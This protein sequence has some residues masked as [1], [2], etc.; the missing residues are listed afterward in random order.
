M[1][2]IRTTNPVLGFW[3]PVV[4]KPAIF[5]GQTYETMTLRAALADRTPYRKFLIIVGLSLIGSVLFSVI[6]GALSELI[7]GVGLADVQKSVPGANSDPG[8]CNAM[9][10]I[11]G[12]SLLGTFFVPALV[13]AWLFSD[14]SI[15]F[16]GA[17]RKPGIRELLI[18]LVL[19]LCAVP[20]I[21]WMMALNQGISLPAS[22]RA[23]EDWMHSMEETASRLTEM[24]VSGTSVIAQSVGDRGSSRDSGRIPF[25]WCPAATVHVARRK[26]TCRYLAH[27]LFV[28]RVAH[29]ISR[30]SSAVHAG[31]LVGIFICLVGFDLASG[32]RT[33]LQQCHSCI[34]DLCLRCR[35]N[36]REPGSVYSLR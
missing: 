20:F 9:R 22:M 6:G 35:I 16:L 10:L 21:N 15:A 13:A 29:A 23:V 11:Q 27:C 34:H 17:I 33:F 8:F 31:R 2:C 7:F 25:S 3:N 1:L 14:D 4:C 32:L 18:V 24:L 19:F 30:I 26:S 36:C 28:Q 12:F 5:A